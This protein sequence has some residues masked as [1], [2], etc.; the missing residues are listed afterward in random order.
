MGSYASLSLGASGAATYSGILTP[1]GATY[2]LGGGGGTLYFASA[3]TGS[4][5]L[6]VS[7]SGTVVLTSTGDTYTAPQRSIRASFQLPA[8]Y[9]AA[10]RSRQTPAA[11]Q[12]H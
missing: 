10:A 9:Q 11:P 1:A 2:R 5:S 8:P 4:N 3:L 6:A 12:F 7:G